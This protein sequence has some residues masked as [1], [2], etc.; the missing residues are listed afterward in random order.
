VFED[1]K[2]CHTFNNG[3]ATEQKFQVFFFTNIRMEGLTLGTKI[4]GK[5][6]EKSSP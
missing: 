1:P 5:F 4:L 3:T 6:R 2:V